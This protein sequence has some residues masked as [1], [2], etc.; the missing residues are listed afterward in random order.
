MGYPGQPT[1]PEVFKAVD[2]ILDKAKQAY[3]QVGTS[4]PADMAL[5]KEWAERAVSCIEA[6]IPLEIVTKSVQKMSTALKNM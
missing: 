2:I 1:H 6:G 5:I 4:I 3:I